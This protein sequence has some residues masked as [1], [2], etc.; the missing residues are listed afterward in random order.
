MS[1]SAFISCILE[2]TG[3]GLLLDVTNLYTNSINFGFDPLR[4]LDSIPCDR[5][6]QLHVAGGHW[7]NGSLIDSHSLPVPDAVWSLVDAACRRA[8][9]KAACIE[10][11]ENLPAF[12]ELCAEIGLLRR[13]GRWN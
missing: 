6:V 7:S 12:S 3:C 13:C 1:E 2:E 10:R 4:W 9:V 8:P 11:D 5:I